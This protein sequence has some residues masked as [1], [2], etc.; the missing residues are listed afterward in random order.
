M[1][2]LPSDE[3]LDGGHRA[4]GRH[5]L[6]EE[7][8]A[9]PRR[10]SRLSVEDLEFEIG[11]VRILDRVSFSLARGELVCVMGP[12]GSGKTTLLKCLNR[13][14]EPTGGRVFLDGADTASFSPV[15]LR[16]RIG[17]VWQTPFMFEGTVRG[18]LRRAVQLS[19][20]GV[21]DEM[22][23]GLLELVAFDGDPDADARVLSVGQQQRV[24]IARALACRPGLLLCDEPTAALDHDNALRLEATFRRLGADGMSVVWVTHDPRQAERIA[25][26]TLRLTDGMLRDPEA[27]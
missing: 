17:M 12:S 9:G 16:R 24:S 8:A 20:S 23:V 19:G 7:A 5:A 15:A 18:N 21:G 14:L 3:R 22:F 10:A 11:G 4:D 26:R 6:A 25:D 2:T 1:S 27:S 13:L